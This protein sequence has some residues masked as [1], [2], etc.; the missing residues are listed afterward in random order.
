MAVS[1]YA[2]MKRMG[3]EA[4]N[5]RPRTTR[6][7]PGH[8]VHPYRLKGL[9]IG[10]PNQV[11]A[12]DITYLP[13]KRGFVSTV[14]AAGSLPSMDGKGAWRN[15]VFI[16]RFWRTL[17]YEA[18]Y[19]RPYE[20]VTDARHHLTNYLV[21][22]SN[23]RPHSSLEDQ[24]PDR[25]YF[26]EL[27]YALLIGL[28]KS[29]QVRRWHEASGSNESLDEY[30]AKVGAR[31]PMGRMAV[32]EPLRFAQRAHRL[33]RSS[34]W[35]TFMANGEARR[36]AP[37][38]FLVL[39][40]CV[41][42]IS[43]EQRPALQPVSSPAE[44]SAQADLKTTTVTVSQGTN[45][46]AAVSPDGQH[47]VISLQGTLFRLPATGGEATAITDSYFD[48]REPAWSND[49]RRIVFHGYRG[50][51][52]DLW[53]IGA[54][55]DG[56][57]ALTSDPYD[58]REPMYSPL[59]N[60][61]V[62]SSDRTGNYD[63]WVLSNGNL[64]QISDSPDNDHSPAWSPDGARIA[65]ASGSSPTSYEIRI[66]DLASG[67]TSTVLTDN[68]RIDGIAWRPDGKGL[69]YRLLSVSV[70]DNASTAVLK[71]AEIATG[72]TQL[73]S[74]TDADVFPFRATWF[75]NDT[76]LYTAGGEIRRRVLDEVET[77]VPFTAALELHRKPYPRKRRTYV[78]AP[79][80]VLGIAFPSI[81]ND[82]RSVVFGALGDLWAIDT[83]TEEITQITDDIYADQNPVFSP[84]G[85][86]IAFVSDRSGKP[87]I[88]IHDLITGSAQL[89]GD[90]MTLSGISWSPDGRE[91]A[92]FVAVPTN[93][94]VSQL[95]SVD[96]ASGR[97]TNHHTPIGSQQTSW[98]S[99]GKAI[100]TA[101]LDTY[102]SRY[103]EG[104]FQLLMIDVETGSTSVHAGLPHKDM[105]KPMLAPDGKSF[106]YVQNGVLWRA[107]LDGNS[108][109]V[110]L[111]TR[112]TD[113]PSW[114]AN[115]EH[116]AYMSGNELVVVSAGQERVIDPGLTYTRANPGKRWV[117]R[118]GRMF[119][120]ITEKYRENVDITINGS[121]IESIAPATS[122]DLELVDMSAMT[123]TPGLF[124]M[125]AHMGPASESQGRAWLANGITSVR[126]PGSDPYLAK[127]RQEAW[128]SGRSI[129]P[130]THITGYLTDGNRVF[131]S[132]AE[133]IASQQHLERVIER[134]RKLKLD[135]IKTYVR[136]PDEWQKRVVDAAHE[137]GIPTSSHE[138]FPAASHGMDHVEHLSGTSRRGYSPKVSQTGYMYEDV[139]KLLASSGMGITP[140]VVF[141]GFALV[142]L[143][144]RDLFETPQ[145][146]A[147]YGEEAFV[148][149]EAFA[150][151]LAPIA[152]GGAKANG[153][154]L[155]DLVD[156]GAL[157]VTGTD[158]PFVPFATGLHAELRLYVRGGLTPFETLR[159]ATSS[160]ATAAGVIED[161]GT[162]E[163]GKLADLVVIDGDPLSEIKD[164][165]NVVMT[166]KNGVAYP[167][168]KLLDR[169]VIAPW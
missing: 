94:R 169:A 23:R 114:S 158:S 132:V 70:A 131:Y 9:T 74:D 63:V 120:G 77:S 109:P 145:Y 61:V 92:G 105:F 22:Y 16:E 25:V 42:L 48:A 84:D 38:H 10:R 59:N 147:F 76:L 130:R 141:P 26:G 139:V 20:S 134:A 81:S 91:I 116:L 79:Q 129:G 156:A 160:S 115:G 103:R 39:L 18:V 163:V 118:V 165:D 164:L 138:V 142:V 3:I 143:E 66:H 32:F 110:Q 85:N 29:D 102:S 40:S 52:W 101:A 53:E 14:H 157:V 4:L 150:K 144:E 46:A 136:L 12:L 37:A 7:H 35:G 127:A 90:G 159:A 51:N 69:S 44:A 56:P 133:G 43:C 100:A 162:I 72:Q 104:V 149:I 82:G 5:R 65:Y 122:H 47:A 80:P 123:V 111:T 86:N 97:I 153:R 168:A 75:N 151:R 71:T 112:L 124:E 31:L 30:A 96:V 41:L 55:G 125:H 8:A 140:T 62:F 68:G 95:V 13:M 49:G 117:L 28:I 58:D 106:T 15:N 152:R 108:V 167:L 34:K 98:S 89:L 88:W 154:A 60:E 99:D 121:R 54:N 146:Q 93:P 155:R 50:G 45:M 17:K 126:D 113:A 27:V 36:P 166:V 128:D 78:S 19:L 73:V 67:E 64:R 137:M 21:F 2:L 161:T 33:Q 148:G 24:T 11:W 6:R 119:D 107:Q 135:F 83:T 1:V 57:R 87:Q